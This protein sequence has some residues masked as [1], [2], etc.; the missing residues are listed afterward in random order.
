[1]R[2][3]PIIENPS[4]TP[5]LSEED[6][7]RFGEACIES[8]EV[9]EAVFVILRRWHEKQ[10]AVALS[11]D[12][13]PEMREIMPYLGKALGCVDTVIRDCITRAIREKQ[14]DAMLDDPGMD[15]INDLGAVNWPDLGEPQ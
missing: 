4:D 5:I 2:L 14:K 7:L 1:M 15:G 3:P 10:S 6:E 8:P 11:T 13:T 9:I 12:G